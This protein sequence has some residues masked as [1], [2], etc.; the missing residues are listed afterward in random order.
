MVLF[1][2]ELA[3][4]LLGIACLPQAWIGPVGSDHQEWLRRH[5]RFGIRA[6]PSNL[7]IDLNTRIDV[8]LLA[9][10][11]SDAIVGVYSFVAVLAEGVFQVG[12]VIR[13][14]INRRLVGVLVSRD[15]AGLRRLRHQTGRWSLAGTLLLAGAIGV[16]F[17]PAVSWL[18]LDRS[19]FQGQYALW[20]LLA[21]VVACAVHS[22]IWMLLL[23]AGRPA[24]H[25]QLML[26][27]CALN[28]LLNI[29]L[30]P[31]FGML[32][33]AIGTAV[34]FAAFPP[35]LTWTANKVLGMKL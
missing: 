17:A 15:H 19:L 35:M 1:A 2:G 8:L 3:A 10:F 9:Y 25:T 29:A 23:L 27:L 7:V 18:G 30:I 31:A 26:A 6:M 16:G 5:L 24:A 13:T 32:G 4:M 33:A 34:M 20:I 14:V 21:G 12:V 22:P 28:I 11:M